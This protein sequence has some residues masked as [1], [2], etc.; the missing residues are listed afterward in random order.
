MGSRVSG[1]CTANR[2][3]SQHPLVNHSTCEGAL[4]NT[5]DWQTSPAKERQLVSDGIFCMLLPKEITSPKHTLPDLAEVLQCPRVLFQE[6]LQKKKEPVKPLSKGTAFV[7]FL[8][9]SVPCTHNFMS[10]G[11]TCVLHVIARTVSQAYEQARLAIFTFASVI[12]PNAHSRLPVKYIECNAHILLVSSEQQI[13]KP[14]SFLPT[15]PAGREWTSM[16]R[17]GHALWPRR[18][19]VWLTVAV[20]RACLVVKVD[21]GTS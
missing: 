13:K 20:A 8:H 12:V 5:D 21:L 7:L 2:W 19:H 11:E 9:G 16:P 14:P 3:L 18:M 17:Q 10:A 4:Q 15:S 6:V 1:G